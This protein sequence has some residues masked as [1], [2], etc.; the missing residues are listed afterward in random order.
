MVRRSSILNMAKFLDPSLKTS[1]CTK[2]SPV[3]CENQSFFLLF[4]NAATFTE[5]HCVFHCYFLQDDEL[6][7]SSL[8]GSYYN[9]HF[10]F[11][12]SVN[13]YISNKDMY[14]SKI[15]EAINHIKNISKKKPTVDNIHKYWVNYD[16]EL[17]NE[18]SYKYF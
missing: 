16:L 7:F 5:R 6:F 14:D 3:S 2:T 17:K 12:D 11:M 13:D 8:L 18:L 1:L 4:R 15:L 9:N 10:V